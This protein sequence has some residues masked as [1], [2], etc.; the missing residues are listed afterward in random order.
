MK[1]DLLFE[2][3]QSILHSAKQNSRRIFFFLFHSKWIFQKN[4]IIFFLIILKDDGKCSLEINLY[5]TEVWEMQTMPNDFAFLLLVKL[6]TNYMN[7][8]Q[9]YARYAKTNSVSCALHYI[10][11]HMVVS[12]TYLRHKKY[13]NQK[14]VYI[15]G[16]HSKITAL[17]SL[18]TT[19]M[20]EC[21]DWTLYRGIISAAAIVSNSF[22]AELPSRKLRTFS[23]KDFSLQLNGLLCWNNIRAVQNGTNAAQCEYRGADG[24]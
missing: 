24:S 15:F 10:S 12:F 8:V 13:G 14:C 20:N 11:W 19:N 3:L 6:E 7:W 21:A 9:C 23:E 1:I 2:T 22:F 4:H 16:W 18:W 5:K 17:Q